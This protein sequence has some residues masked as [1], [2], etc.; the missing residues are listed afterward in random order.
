[1]G[2]GAMAAQGAVNSEVI[3]SSPII[4]A[5]NLGVRMVSTPAVEVGG[6]AIPTVVAGYYI[7]HWCNPAAREVLTLLV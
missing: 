3:G 1:M 6:A 4:P 5:S 2:C 7:G